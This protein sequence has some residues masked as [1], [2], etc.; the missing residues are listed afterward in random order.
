MSYYITIKEFSGI[1]KTSLFDLRCDPTTVHDLTL[2]LM[3]QDAMKTEPVYQSLPDLADDLSDEAFIQLWDQQ[4][5]VFSDL[6]P[7]FATNPKEDLMI[8]PQRDIHGMRQLRYL[9]N[10]GLHIH[11]FFEINYVFQGTCQFFFK[12]ELHT[13]HKGELCLI[14][15]DSPHDITIADETCGNKYHHP[16][17]HFPICFYGSA[18]SK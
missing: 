14:A 2:S 17:K 12:E 18:L 6:S 13:M 15:P 4:Y 10:G 11:D 3:R 7:S 5:L 8:P 9:N 1:F 16:K